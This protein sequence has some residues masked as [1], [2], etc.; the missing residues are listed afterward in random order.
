M[1]LKAFLHGVRLR[2]RLNDLSADISVNVANFIIKLYVSFIPS[3]V[4]PSGCF[5]EPL[6]AWS[7]TYPSLMQSLLPV[8]GSSCSVNPKWGAAYC[9]F[10]FYCQLVIMFATA[11]GT[12]T[13]QLLL[14]YTSVLYP[15]LISAESRLSEHQAENDSDFEIC[16]SFFQL[17]LCLK[18]GS[19]CLHH[20]R[21]KEK[22]MPLIDWWLDFNW[23]ELCWVQSPMMKFY[24]RFCQLG[25]STVEHQILRD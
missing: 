3:S 18:N 24:K 6:V 5:R 13:S 22:L 2:Y 11:K 19:A 4:A 20:H 25:G 17:F 9:L 7:N 16:L 12:K 8:R 1:L 15:H 14:Y 23:L 21:E 10:L